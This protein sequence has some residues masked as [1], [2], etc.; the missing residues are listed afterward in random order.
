MCFLPHHT[1]GWG[2]PTPPQAGETFPPGAP[3]GVARVGRP[4]GVEGIVALRGDME[5]EARVPGGVGA[6]RDEVAPVGQAVLSAPRPS[7]RVEAPG[8]RV[9][10]HLRVVGEPLLL[11]H[12]LTNRAELGRGRPGDGPLREGL[13]RRLRLGTTLRRSGKSCN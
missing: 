12:V 10:Y 7:L 8:I 5:L 4:P 3:L 6:S 1:R 13:S 9:V 11:G 2:S